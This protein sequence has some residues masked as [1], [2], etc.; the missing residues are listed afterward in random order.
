VLQW[1]NVELGTANVTLLGELQKANAII[2]ELREKLTKAE[3]ILHTLKASGEP[4]G[5]ALKGDAPTEDLPA[6][7]AKPQK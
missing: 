1:A 4:F 6:N 2:N 7:L 3:E 5:A